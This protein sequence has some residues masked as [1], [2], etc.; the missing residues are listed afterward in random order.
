MSDQN[1]D[2]IAALEEILKQQTAADQPSPSSAT[3]EQ[4][5]EP[6]LTLE[7]A[8]R[9]MAKQRQKD[10]RAYQHLQSQLDSLK[11]TPQ[12]QAVQAQAAREEAEDSQQQSDLEG[13]E[14]RQLEH[15]KMVVE[16]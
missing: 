8:R 6:E 15:T 2:P 1:Q 4:P 11:D 5:V 13:H 10:D 12:Y 14:I 7:E 3:Q 16:E 9:L